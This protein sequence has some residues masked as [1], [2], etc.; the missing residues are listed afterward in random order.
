[1]ASLKAMLMPPLLVNS[2]SDRAGGKGYT[3]YV[4]GWARIPGKE[5]LMIVPCILLTLPIQ[6]IHATRMLFSMC[7]KV[8]L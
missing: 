6:S 1:M 2:T 3:G 7:S 5:G 8:R 4:T